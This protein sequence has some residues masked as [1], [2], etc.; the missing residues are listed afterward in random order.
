MVVRLFAVLLL[1]GACA[2]PLCADAD[3]AAGAPVT[4]YVGINPVSLCTFLPPPY[5][6]SVTGFGMASGQ[7]SG[8]ALYG[9]VYPASGHGLE[10]RLSTGPADLVIWETQ[11]QLGYLW[12]PAESLA[13]WSGGPAIG[14]MIRNFAF[15]NQFN[16]KWIFNHV[17]ELMVGW[18]FWL[19]S[20]AIDARAGWNILSCTWSTVPHSTPGFVL[21]DFP[22]NLNLMLGIA[23]GF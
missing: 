5:S 8:L 3:T 19:G 6:N 16:G 1:L 15:A 20:L 18:R 17:P 7:E 13:G 2:L 10:L 23:W 11:A 9:G 12:Y 4:S 14:F 22:Y 21:T